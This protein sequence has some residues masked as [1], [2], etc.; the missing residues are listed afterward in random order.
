MI[1]RQTVNFL[2]T[3][4]RLGF[5]RYRNGRLAIALYDTHGA[6][7]ATATINVPAMPLAPNQ[8]LIKDYDENAGLLAALEDAGIVRPTGVR[9]RLGYVQADV[10]QLLI[11]APAVH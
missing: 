11:P 1:D 2:N 8:V 10:C 5:G 9:C 6:P 4:C 7:F 3:P